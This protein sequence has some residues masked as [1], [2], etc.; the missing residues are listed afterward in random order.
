VHTKNAIQHLK[1]QGKTVIVIAHRL[2][3]VLN[4]DTLIVID[5]GKVVEQGTPNELKSQEVFFRRMLQN[6]GIGI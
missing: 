3:T 2:S 5:E 6:Q 1:R 4:A